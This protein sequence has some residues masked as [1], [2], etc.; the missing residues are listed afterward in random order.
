MFHFS[1]HSASPGAVSRLVAAAVVT[2]MA[3][4][5]LTLASAPTASAADAFDGYVTFTWGN[6]Y[7]SSDANA[8]KTPDVGDTVGLG[9]H[10]DAGAFELT[11]VILHA[12]GYAWGVPTRPAG[13]SVGYGTQPATVKSGMLNTLGTGP[14]FSGASLDYT[15]DGATHTLTLPNAPVLYT[16]PTPIT[17]STSFVMTENHGFVADQVVEGDQVHYVTHVTNTSEVALAITAAGYATA[18]APFSLAAGASID[19]IGDSVDVTYEDM[20]AGGITFADASV[21]WDAGDVAGSVPVTAGTAPTEE[22]DTSVIADVEIVVNTSGGAAV[23]LGDAVAGDQ[24]DYTFQLQNTGNVVYQYVSVERRDR[25][26][27]LDGL[28][29]ATSPATNL[30]QGDSLPNANFPATQITSVGGEF[31]AYPLKQADIDLGYVDIDF[32]IMAAPSTAVIDADR[33]V[34][35]YPISK[36]VYLRAFNTDASLTYP[37]AQLNDTNGDGIGNAGETVSYRA[38][39]ENLSDQDVLLYTLSSHT[40]P[41]VS[42]PAIDAFMRQTVSPEN[43]IDHEWEYTVTTDDEAR[44][45]LD[46]EMTVNYVGR[47]D[48]ANAVTTGSARTVTTGAYVAPATTLDTSGTYDD[49]NGD[50]FP[51][52]G[53][54]VTY[55]VTVANTGTWDRTGVSVGEAAGADVTG[56]LPVFSSTIAAGT[57]ETQTFTHVITAADFARGSLWYS[58]EMI[59]NGSATIQSGT[60]VTL[61][62]IT[63][64]AY[65]TDLDAVAEGGVAVCLPTGVSTDSITIGDTIWVKPGACDYVGSADGFRAVAFS[66]PVT[67]GVGT[68]AVT[69][70]E[71]LGVG[72]HRL[73]LYASDGSLVGW[74]SV[75]VAELVVYEEPNA[76]GLAFT[77]VDSDQVR[78]IAGGAVALM[79]LG[80]AAIFVTNRRKKA[81]E[82]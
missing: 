59:A 55:D 26:I 46:A 6:P 16:A 57:S 2:L 63:F 15:A 56:L 49:A 44:G 76:G 17:V 18:T 13:S 14:T 53:E 9:V 62:G 29:S 64:Q 11:D 8:D 78:G 41:N 27:F 23:A 77:G 22:I 7:L 45:T 81:G 58:T 51:S 80:A 70:P 19:L 30:A 60:S 50:G 47:A 4:L 40:A 37:K 82:I 75:T 48:G 74:K 71:V 73:A 65:S 43:Q 3:A 38:E 20:V 10:I 72:N 68:F 39:F 79:L 21:A 34:Y 66:T 24:I 28:A 31:P 61:T 54:T 52:I 35:T 5:G 36:R 25:G 12:G 1:S 33:S 42:S 69:V 67:L 32:F